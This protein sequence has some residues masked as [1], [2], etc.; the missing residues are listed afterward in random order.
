MAPHGPSTA[1]TISYGDSNRPICSG[2]I[3]KTITLQ[4]QF[5]RLAAFRMGRHWRIIQDALEDNYSAMKGCRNRRT[6]R[7]RQVVARYLCRADLGS[8]IAIVDRN[9]CRG[10]RG[11]VGRPVDRR[12]TTPALGLVAVLALASYG[13]RNNDAP[14]VIGDPTGDRSS[15]QIVAIPNGFG[16]LATKYVVL[17]TRIYTIHHSAEPYGSVF[18]VPADGSCAR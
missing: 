13:Q 15:D 6:I 3:G 8:Q 10:H 14:V 4:D 12:G 1:R 2:R 11:V 9:G 16:N 17:G 18:V 7:P 5:G